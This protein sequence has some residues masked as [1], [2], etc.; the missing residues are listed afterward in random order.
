MYPLFQ[1]LL[2]PDYHGQVSLYKYHNLLLSYELKQ[3][4]PLSV[5]STPQVCAHSP[6]HLQLAFALQLEVILFL[7]Y[8]TACLF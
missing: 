5:S 8:S 2:F 7:P 4:S 1:D 3:V 6:F